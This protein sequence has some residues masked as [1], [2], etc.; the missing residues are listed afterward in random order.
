LGEER[1]GELGARDRQQDARTELQSQSSAKQVFKG[2]ATT[3][4]TQL[5]EHPLRADYQRMLDG[6]TKPN[7][8]KVTLARKVASIVLAM[9]KHQ[10]VYDTVKYNMPSS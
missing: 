2:A 6:G 4:V 8:A 9:W 5:S 3:I 1:E 10:E 7:L